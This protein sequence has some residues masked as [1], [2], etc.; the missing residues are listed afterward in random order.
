MSHDVP[1]FTTFSAFYP[2]YLHEHRDKTNRT[3]HFIGTSL[4]ILTLVALLL[5][6]NLKLFFV[7]P[8]FGYGFAWVG[9]YVFEKN[10]P[11]TFKYPLF[12][13]AGD[14]R[15]FYELLTGQVRFESQYDYVKFERK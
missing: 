15:M 12:S 14:F 6:G 3:L 8:L 10:R 2:F 4:V 7:A 11:A 5:T 9:H 1:E 13:L